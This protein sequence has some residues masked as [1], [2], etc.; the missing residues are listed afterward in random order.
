MQP[1]TKSAL[2]VTLAQIDDRD[3][4]LAAVASTLSGEPQELPDELLNSRQSCALLG[5]SRATLYRNFRPKLW[6]GRL[7][8]WSRRALLQ[9]SR[10]CG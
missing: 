4:R 10:S 9:G 7:P 8:R 6:A 2:L 1:V 3:P 5:I